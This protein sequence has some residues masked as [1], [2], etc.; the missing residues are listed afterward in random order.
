MSP[1]LIEILKILAPL[2]GGGLAGAILGT[3]LT[4]RR[5]R[6]QPVTI[7]KEIIPIVNQQLGDST[8]QAEVLLKV[9]GNQQSYSNLMLGRVTIRNTGNLD[10]KEFKFEVTLNSL[11]LAVYLQTESEDRSHIISS[12]PPIDLNHLDSEIDF[13]LTPFNR[14]DTYSFSLFILP[15]PSIEEQ[16][17]ISLSTQHPVK[18]VDF[19]EYREIATSLMWD[20]MENTRVVGLPVGLP[21]RV[22]RKHLLK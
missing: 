3:Y 10:Y 13:T 15:A 6:I 22:F 18:F 1:T 9:A 8:V 21:I 4:N 7:R 20:L 16:L 14:G 12:T 17:D 5:N 11:N 19:Q 2:I